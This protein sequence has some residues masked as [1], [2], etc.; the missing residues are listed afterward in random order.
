MGSPHLLLL[1][2]PVVLLLLQFGVQQL[3]LKSLGTKLDPKTINHKIQ[4]TVR[5]SSAQ[6]KNRGKIRSLG[7]GVETLIA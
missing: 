6:R 3:A 7:C 4:S 2:L 1:L 5:V